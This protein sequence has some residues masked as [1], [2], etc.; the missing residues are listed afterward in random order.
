MQL[1]P[2]SYIVLGLLSFGGELTPYA[3]KQA[4]ELSIGYFWSFPHSQLYAEP[5]RLAKA[6]YVSERRE[7]EGRRRRHYRL[8]DRGHE[9]LRQW[10]EEP[11]AELPELRDVSLLKMFLGADP[12]IL[13]PVQLR[14]HR[15]RLARY[16][17]IWEAG[18]GTD[19]PEGA[20]RALAAGLRAEREW[21][22]YWEE[23]LDGTDPGG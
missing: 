4:V 11:T 2:T 23:V 21:I 10:R 15:D 17:E 7:A 8:T 19:A 18:S 6:G 9:V 14:A 5:E 13:A 16:E 22:A 1:T 12:A 20:R 3:M